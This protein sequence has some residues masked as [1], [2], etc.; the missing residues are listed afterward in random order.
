MIDPMT[1]ESLASLGAYDE[2]GQW[3]PL[4]GA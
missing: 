4:S 1:G 3:R 2:S